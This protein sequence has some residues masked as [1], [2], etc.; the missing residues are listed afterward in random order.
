[1]VDDD[2]D[3]F[4]LARQAFKL[5]GQER[6]FQLVSDGEE[7]MDYLYRRKNSKIF[8]ILPCRA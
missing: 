8:K 6:D 4:Y 1:M 7:L 2:P 5:S 3:D